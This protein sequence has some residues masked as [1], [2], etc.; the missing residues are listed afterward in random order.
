[1]SRNSKLSYLIEGIESVYIHTNA[2]W[3][4]E[5]LDLNILVPVDLTQNARKIGPTAMQL[6]PIMDLCKRTVLITPAVNLLSTSQN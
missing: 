6:G 5:K 1:M 3:H 4:S 2:V